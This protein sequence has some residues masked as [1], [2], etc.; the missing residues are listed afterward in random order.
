MRSQIRGELGVL[1]VPQG[2]D[3]ADD[4][5][6]VNVVALGE[7]PGREEESVL[8]IF[9]DRPEQLPAARIEF[10]LRR[11]DA[12]FQSSRALPEISGGLTAVRKTTCTRLSQV[13]TPK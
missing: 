13:P 2:L 9:E 12:L 6:S 11:C 1:V 7:F 8:G 10:S 4:G 5:R 3:G